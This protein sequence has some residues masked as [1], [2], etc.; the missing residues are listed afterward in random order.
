M[1]KKIVSNDFYE[2]A[3]NNEKNRVFFKIFGFWKDPSDVPDYLADWE[4][5]TDEL[6]PGFTIVSDF[7]QMKTPSTA[8]APLHQATQEFLVKKG[9]DRTAE[10]MEDAVLLEFQLKRYA[11][12]S[13]M[14]KREFKTVEEG[15]AWLDND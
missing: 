11:E 4:R 12:K 14:K 9:L 1:I 2:L 5:T 10:I 7:R 8:V 15:E 3:V 6:S 13:S